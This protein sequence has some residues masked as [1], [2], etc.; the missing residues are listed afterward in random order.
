MARKPNYRFERIQRDR[1]KAAKKAAK[2]AA[3]AARKAAARAGDA[4]ATTEEVAAPA[5]GGEE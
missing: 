1:D 2:R 3:R 5:P 4:P